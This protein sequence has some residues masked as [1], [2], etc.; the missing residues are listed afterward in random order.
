MA[1]SSTLGGAVA[2]CVAMGE[3]VAGAHPEAATRARPNAPAVGA[4]IEYCGDILSWLMFT[5]FLV[6]GVSA[7][8][9]PM[10]RLEHAASEADEVMHDRLSAWNQLT[11]H[12]RMGSRRQIAIALELPI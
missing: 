3:E 9:V 5:P 12:A 11:S 4:E 7:R 2:A 8:I 10:E 6:P 1:P